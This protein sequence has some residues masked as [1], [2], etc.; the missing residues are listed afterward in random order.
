MIEYDI[1][2][3]EASNVITPGCMVL[4]GGAFRGLYT[5]GVLDVLM[6]EGINLACTIGVSAGALS[7]INYVSGQIGRSAIVNL[8]YRH[9]P[10]YIGFGAMRHDHG[11]TGFSYLF[12]EIGEEWPLDEERFND[13]GRRF[14]AVA[15]NVN[16]AKAEYF[17]RGYCADINKACAASASVPYISEPVEID[18]EYYLDGAIVDPI[19]VDWAIKEGYEKIVVIRTR[20]PSFR[21]TVSRPLDIARV[22]Y[23]KYP[24]LKSVLD[25][26]APRY[27]VRV[28]GINTLE[29]QGRVFVIAPSEPINISRFEGDLDALYEVYRLGIKDAQENLKKLKDYLGINDEESK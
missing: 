10:D 5:Q 6:Q 19:P 9:D 14:I 4:E 22:E 18:G 8:S 21:K 13:P 27:N 17:E 12:G 7:G 1:L 11:I 24:K 20:E 15:T 26:Q 25:E 23:R 28:D 3:G 16:T 29:A 2:D